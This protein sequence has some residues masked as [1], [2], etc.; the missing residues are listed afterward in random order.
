MFSFKNLKTTLGSGGLLGSGVGR[1]ALNTELLWGPYIYIYMLRTKQLLRFKTLEEKIV[2]SY[3]TGLRKLKTINA[4][5]PQPQ[6][7]VLK[8]FA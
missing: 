5:A 7:T 8:Y 1:A 2:R 3:G 4:I 6:H